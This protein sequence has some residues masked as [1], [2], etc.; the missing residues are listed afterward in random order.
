MAKAR[1]TTTWLWPPPISTISRN[2]GLA[3]VNMAQL[4]GK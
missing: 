2:T 1:N 4:P 3:L